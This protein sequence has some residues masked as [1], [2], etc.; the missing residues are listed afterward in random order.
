MNDENR[1]L[2]EKM[3]AGSEDAF[4]ALYHSF[5]QRLYR[6]AY[7]ITRNRADSEDILQETFVTCFLHRKDLKE[8]ECF[9]S[10]IY[11]ILIRAARRLEKQKGRAG[12]VSFDRILEDE[13]Q[14]GLAERISRD[15]AAASPLE[16][17]LEQEVAAELQK[18]IGLLDEKHR[19]VILLYYYNGLSTKEIAQ[20]TRTLEGT[21]KSRLYKSRA[22]LKTCLEQ[23]GYQE[24]K[25]ER[26]LC[27]EV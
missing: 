15:I 27:H 1:I 10:W 21:V 26:G 16:Q 2:V 22:L 23:Y 6:M 18:A 9:E 14:S 11:Q 13:D 8:P 12:T 20:I 4:D 25:K 5:S 3:I 24:S 17:V 7:F 19:T